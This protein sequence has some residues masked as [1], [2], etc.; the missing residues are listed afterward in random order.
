[1]V[2]LGPR[3]A[4]LTQRALAEL[5]DAADLAPLLDAV[6]PLVGDGTFVS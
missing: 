6:L 5:G 4:D 2:A 3:N 1:V